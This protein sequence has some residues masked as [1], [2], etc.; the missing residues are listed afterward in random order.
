[1]KKNDY[2]K[3]PEYI[4]KVNKDKLEKIRADRITEIANQIERC[5][6]TYYIGEN[7]ITQI[8]GLLD[9]KSK[10]ELLK[11][12]PFWDLSFHSSITTLGIYKTDITSITIS[13][14]EQYK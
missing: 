5:I 10:D 12:F 1:M 6:K 11:C 3:T 14:K 8:D 9:T 4:A 13:A 7:L 2:Y